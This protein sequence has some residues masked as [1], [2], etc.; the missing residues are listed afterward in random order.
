MVLSSLVAKQFVSF[1][2]LHVYSN[3]DCLL[4]N[5]YMTTRCNVLATLGV[6]V[7]VLECI[8][9][10]LQKKLTNMWYKIA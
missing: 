6:C 10:H 2:T 9:L 5:V 4:R 8:N 7:C 3:S 1:S